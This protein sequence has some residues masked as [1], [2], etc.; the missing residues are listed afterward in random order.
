MKSGDIVVIKDNVFDDVKYQE[1][2]NYSSKDKVKRAIGK[3]LKITE[4][5]PSGY[6][7]F[8]KK[9]TLMIPVN[10]LMTLREVRYKK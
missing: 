2:S 10:S 5:S 8:L 6:F 9:Y 1:V 3:E 7:V 4:V